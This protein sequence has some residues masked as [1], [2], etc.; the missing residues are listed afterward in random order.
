MISA[1]IV[2][3]SSDDEEGKG[4]DLKAVKLEPEVDGAMMLL[5]GHAKKNIIKHEKPNTEFVSQVFDENRSPNVLSAGQSSSSILDQVLSPA[6]DSGLTSPSPLC[7]A[8]VCRQFWK[9]GN[10]DDGVASKVTVQSTMLFCLITFSISKLICCDISWGYYDQKN[11]GL[12]FLLRWICEELLN[13]GV[14]FLMLF[15]NGRYQRP[16]PCPPYVPSFKC[17]FTQ[18]GFWRY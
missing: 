16:S 13:S 10:Y 8:P 9:A 7:P 14:L 18:V 11:P 4:S 2:D 6:D 15:P 17:Y 5:K 12:N 1:D 3:L